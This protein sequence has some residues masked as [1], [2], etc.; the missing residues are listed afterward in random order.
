MGEALPL[1]AGR[2]TDFPSLVSGSP[3]SF[4][5]DP[6]AILGR[7]KKREEEPCWEGEL[8]PRFNTFP[9]ETVLKQKRLFKYH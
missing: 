9:K 4:A 2:R 7:R 3:I 1:E 6:S 5:L 8:G